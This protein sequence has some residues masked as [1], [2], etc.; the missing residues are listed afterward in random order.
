M[1]SQSAFK[2]VSML[3]KKTIASL[4]PYVLQIHS[5]MKIMFPYFIFWIIFYQMTTISVFEGKIESH[6]IEM[7]NGFDERIK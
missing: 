1:Q 7:Q 3:T 4:I 2:L 6:E 5:Y